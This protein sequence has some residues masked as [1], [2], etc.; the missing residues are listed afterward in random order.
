[1]MLLLLLLLS[2]ESSINALIFRLFYHSAIIRLFSRARARSPLN[3]RA[4]KNFFSSRFFFVR[5]TVWCVFFTFTRI[6]KIAKSV[7][8]WRKKK[9]GTHRCCERTNYE[10]QLIAYHYTK[11]VFYGFFFLKKKENA[12]NMENVYGTA[13]MAVYFIEG[14]IRRGWTG[15]KICAK[16]L[17]FPWLYTFLVKAF[18]GASKCL[19]LHFSLWICVFFFVCVRRKK[20]KSGDTRRKYL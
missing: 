3:Q 5:T 11:P 20:K 12:N 13:I 6:R 1:M 18:A 2:D 19:F 9:N 17:I 16:F 10:Q 8:R 7:H 14:Q 4:Q 15:K